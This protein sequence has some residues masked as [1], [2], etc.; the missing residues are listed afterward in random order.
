M[1]IVIPSSLS[2]RDD[3]EHLA[4][5]LGVERARDLVEQQR[6]RPRGERAGD[7]HALLLAAREPVGVLVLAAR[8]PEAG[9]Q[10]A[11][12]R[13]RLGA[14]D[15]RARAPGASIDVLERAQVREQVERLEDHAEPAAHRDRRRPTGR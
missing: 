10:L 5:E 8:Q 9:E 2:S 14:R 3:L 15:R 6:A 12:A 4:D 7:R 11:G 1:S 13:L